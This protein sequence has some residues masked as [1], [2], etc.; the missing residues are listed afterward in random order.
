VISVTK[1]ALILNSQHWQSLPQNFTRRYELFTCNEIYGEILNGKG[2]VY[3][4]DAL[5][6]DFT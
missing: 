6:E 1:M 5:I 4:I 3:S 2:S